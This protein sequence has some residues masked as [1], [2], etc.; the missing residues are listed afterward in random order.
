M[1]AV[2]RALL[3]WLTGGSA[4]ADLVKVLLAVCVLVLGLIYRRNLGILGADRRRPAERRAYDALRE[5]L[6]EGMWRRV[7]TP[8]GS[9]DFSTGL[10]AS[11]AT[12]AWRTE[13][14]SHTPSG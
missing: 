8:S 1:T 13:H 11:S 10:T 4:L 2:G 5:S 9:P 12:P 14:S 7:S 6:A 3:T